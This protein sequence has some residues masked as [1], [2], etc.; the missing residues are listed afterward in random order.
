MPGMASGLRV[1]SLQTFPSLVHDFT[2]VPSEFSRSAAK[3]TTQNAVSWHVNAHSMNLLA[4][5][6]GWQPAL[7][8]QQGENT[9]A[10]LH[11]ISEDG[12]SARQ[13]HERRAGSCSAPSE[14][15][16]IHQLIVMIR[17]LRSP[18][19]KPEAPLYIVCSATEQASIIVWLCDIQRKG[20]ASHAVH[21]AACCNFHISSST[22]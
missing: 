11:G 1:Y 19:I 7:P 4:G 20:I 9:A 3:H 13:G 2:A 6:R 14:G 5:S 18:Q 8:H 16:Q 17:D 21:P 15:M 22:R 10:G 12:T